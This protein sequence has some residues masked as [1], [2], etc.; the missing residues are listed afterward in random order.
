ME[1]TCPFEPDPVNAGVGMDL[2]LY[3]H[4]TIVSDFYLN[5]SFL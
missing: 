4:V 5:R 2:F 3:R 1:I